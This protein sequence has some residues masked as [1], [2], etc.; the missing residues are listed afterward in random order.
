M[1]EIQ[2][3]S[4]KLDQP[5]RLLFLQNNFAMTLYPRLNS[6]RFISP[7]K[8]LVLLLLVTGLLN[9]DALGQQIT[10]EGSVSINGQQ[11]P[12]DLGAEAFVFDV[13][14]G[15]QF[16]YPPTP[17]SSGRLT[18]SE[19]AFLDASL[20]QI[21][22]EQSTG[23]FE[24]Q[25]F[26]TSVAVSQNIDLLFGSL[27]VSDGASVNSPFLSTST[28]SIFAPTINVS[29]SGSLLTLDTVS[30]NQGTLNI[31]DAGA[32]SAFSVELGNSNGFPFSLPARINLTDGGQAAIDNLNLGFNPQGRSEVS[33]GDDSSLLV[34]QNFTI[35]GDNVVTLDGG[36]LLGNPNFNQ[37]FNIS[38]SGELRGYGQ[39]IGNIQ[40]EG[41]SQ[42]V[43]RLTVTA[44]QTLRTS[45]ISNFTGQITNFGT[46][47]AGSN[48]ILNGFNGRY[49]GENST[50]RANELFNDGT[51]N[52]TAGRNFVE[53]VLINF[54]DFNISGG[55]SVIFTDEVIN[56][57]VIHTGDGSTS[58][59]LD[60]L[61]GSGVF[62]G[63]GDVIILGQF[64]PG[65]ALGL[66]SFESDLKLGA[67]ASTAIQLSG[68]I[69]STAM[70]LSST[71]RFD[72]VDVGGTL[73][74]GG[75]LV[76]GVF[77]G[78]DIE[79][80]QEFII[81][82]VE[83]SL[84]GQFNDLP[85]GASVGSFGG[86]DLFISYVA[87]D[88]N[89]VSLFSAAGPEFIL[90]DVNQDGVVD[91]F[92]IAPFIAILSA[93]DFLEQADI[94]QDGIVNFFD[95]SPFIGILSGN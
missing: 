35:D 68:P 44:D 49:L 22:G 11:A 89:D 33:I 32:F 79:P 88:G 61:C 94:N 53:A 67:G 27:S 38:E 28:N 52:L 1:L 59:I 12:P 84:I 40:L 43:H 2:V 73:T 34:L 63:E 25:G 86:K 42:S 74:L 80:G 48:S 15:D 51:L 90:G 29:G 17:S 26:G 36:W 69:R 66:V 56:N 78:F 20:L 57:G 76:I 23:V 21:G 91:F 8:P 81:A 10:S 31:S 5:F 18:V 19:G 70:Q 14:I 62:E 30:L 41:S 9:S 60:T 54:G 7:L 65:S 85:E 39:V 46:L 4:S 6:P 95:I 82:D 3:L 47:D 16:F 55:A 83:D 64:A 72:A 50:I 71:D 24:A 92:D 87:G 37:S 75:D 45:D 93:S 13:Q 77:D 58:T